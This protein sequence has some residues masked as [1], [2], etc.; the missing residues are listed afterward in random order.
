MSAYIDDIKSLMK[1][2]ND[3]RSSTPIESN[4]ALRVGVN[5]ELSAQAI[6]CVGEKD[7]RDYLYD[8]GQEIIQE[9]GDDEFYPINPAPNYELIKQIMDEVYE[10]LEFELTSGS[11]VIA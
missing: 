7:F 1:I 6:S 4:L 5:I 3:V 11:P 9:V 2:I 8:K 10:R